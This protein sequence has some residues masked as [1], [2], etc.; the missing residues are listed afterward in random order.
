MGEA[1]GGCRCGSRV[2]EEGITFPRFRGKRF[3]KSV[4]FPS[5]TTPWRRKF[6]VDVCG[7]LGIVFA[8]LEVTRCSKA[9][10]FCGVVPILREKFAEVDFIF[11]GFSRAVV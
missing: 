10:D 4:T 9:S 8:S 1:L 6:S 5:V 7:T 3:S 11:E 2:Q